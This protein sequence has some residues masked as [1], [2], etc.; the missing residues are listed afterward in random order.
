MKYPFQRKKNA[1]NHR[2]RF[3][4]GYFENLC[5]QTVGAKGPEPLGPYSLLITIVSLSARSAFSAVKIS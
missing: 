4:Q 2:K 5:G 1:E 3:Y